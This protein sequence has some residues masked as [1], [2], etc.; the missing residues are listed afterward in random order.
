MHLGLI[1]AGNISGTHAR[2]AAAIDGVR[3]AAVCGRTRD[4][5][6]RLARE[7]G[8]A[9]YD[10]LERFLDHR[11]LDAVAIGTPSGLH[12][13]HGIAAAARGL[14]VLV[15][16]PIDVTTDAADRLIA[17]AARAGVTLGVIFQDRLRP[18]VRRLKAMIDGGRLGAPVLAAA[19]V[20][21]YRPPAYYA[22]SRWRGTR[23]LDGGGALM[24]QG[25][26]TV[27]L[28]LHLCGPV[29]RVTGRTATRLHAIE[30]E[31]TAVATLEFASGAIGTIEA[32]TSAYPGYPRRIE[33][34]G[35]NGTVRLEGDAIAAID[36]RDEPRMSRPSVEPSAAAASPVVADAS[37]HQAVFEDFVAA[38]AARRPP[39]C[40]GRSA[41]PSVAVIEAIYE[42]SRRGSA[43]DVAPE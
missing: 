9:P 26:H 40:D 5:A 13:A 34:T 27:D 12:A 22:A 17:A 16:K 43:I 4:A 36:L 14:H 20:R 38:V 1:G 32:A 15:E 2:A 3:V 7:Y 41:R 39:M 6:E 37:A 10:D 19:A 29:R 23:A 33:L 35:S 8:A 24:N 11:P 28:L 42:S 18:D 30:V 25:V 21:W 31:D